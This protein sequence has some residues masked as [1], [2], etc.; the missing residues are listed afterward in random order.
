MIFGSVTMYFSYFLA[1][2]ADSS[3]VVDE[4][5]ILQADPRREGFDASVKST[6]NLEAAVTPELR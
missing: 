6:L 4:K 1:T 3:P 2:I 5:G